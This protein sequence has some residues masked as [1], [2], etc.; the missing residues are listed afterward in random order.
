M[1][2][3]INMNE[4]EKRRLVKME[5]AIFGDGNGD[6][7]MKKQLD[8]MHDWM[9]AFKLGGVLLKAAGAIII[10]LGAIAYGIT[11]LKNFLK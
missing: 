3:A 10:T 2:Q 8:D 5:T 1:I 11:Q 7:G 4:D 6:P 9:M